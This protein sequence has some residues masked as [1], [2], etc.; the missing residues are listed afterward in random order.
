MEITKAKAT[1]IEPIMRIYGSAKEF[2]KRSGNPTQWVDGYPSKEL[3][4]GDIE[5]GRLYIC[6]DSDGDIVAVFCY[7]IAN[8]P[9]YDV[10]YDGEWLNDGEYGVVHRIASSGKVRRVSDYCLEWCY[11]QHPNMRIDTHS[12]NI[13]M[14]SALQRLGY[15]QCGVIICCNGS[16]RLAFHRSI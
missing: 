13:T 4:M 5:F 7:F 2:M 9:T 11:A 10:I 15:T 12:D 14:Q 8:D 1:D 16:E 3:V 6:R